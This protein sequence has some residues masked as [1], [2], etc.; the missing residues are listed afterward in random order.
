[1][2]VNRSAIGQKLVSRR[3]V[4]AAAAVSAVP[5]SAGAWHL[6]SKDSSGQSLSKAA[7]ATGAAARPVGQF[8]DQRPSEQDSYIR[9]VC[10]TAD[11]Q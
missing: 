1:M 4:I 7:S 8:S 10:F 3:S 5:L 9:S 11:N 2:D 6:L